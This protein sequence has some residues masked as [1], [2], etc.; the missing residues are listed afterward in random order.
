MIYSRANFW[1]TIRNHIYGKIFIPKYKDEEAM[2]INGQHEPLISE[3]LFYKVQDV[4]DGNKR[5]V[6]PKPK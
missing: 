3:A 2:I 4:L 5:N 1:T 6:R